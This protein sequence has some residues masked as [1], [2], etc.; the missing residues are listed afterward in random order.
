MYLL[1]L[2]QKQSIC[3]NGWLINYLKILYISYLITADIVE[4][5]GK[6]ISIGAFHKTIKKSTVISVCKA[7]L[8]G[9]SFLEGTQRFGND[10][11][12]SSI[13]KGDPNEDEDSSNEKSDDEDDESEKKVM[14][15]V[16]MKKPPPPPV[17]ET[18]KTVAKKVIKTP[19]R[20]GKG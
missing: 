14:M 9:T 7:I 19:A 12:F 3:L 8:P 20:G 13:N 1:E 16:M 5:N 10:V 18:K 2:R 6:V 15:R 17:V 11:V 4:D